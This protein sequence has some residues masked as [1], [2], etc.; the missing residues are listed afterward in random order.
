MTRS[1]VIVPHGKYHP[2]SGNLKRVAKQ[3]I[4]QTSEDI[5]EAIKIARV[6]ETAVIL[7]ADTKRHRTAANMLATAFVKAT[8]VVD[9]DTYETGKS[10]SGSSELHPNDEAKRWIKATPADSEKNSAIV[11]VTSD[12]YVRRLLA[13][14]ISLLGGSVELPKTLSRIDDLKGRYDGRGEPIDAGGGVHISS[15]ALIY[16]F[17]KTEFVPLRTSEEQTLRNAA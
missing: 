1:L 10:T 13:S 6:G 9:A 11:A 4:K 8:V 5:K 12:E 2:K 3:E 7:A 15:Q 16:D 17:D 14:Q